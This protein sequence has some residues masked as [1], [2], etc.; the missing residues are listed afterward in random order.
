MEFPVYGELPFR[1]DIFTARTMTDHLVTNA[2]PRFV[3]N[4]IFDSHIPA[5]VAHCCG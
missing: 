4:D 3:A 1:A 2:V 5:A